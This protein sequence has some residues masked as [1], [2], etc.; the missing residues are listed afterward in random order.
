MG[1]EGQASSLDALGN[2]GGLC[3]AKLQITRSTRN[4]P[5]SPT[6][7]SHAE[8]LSNPVKKG[9]INFSRSPALRAAKNTYNMILSAVR[10]PAVP[11]MDRSAAPAAFEPGGIGGGLGRAAPPKTA[12]YRP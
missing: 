12:V 4:L 9:M 3:W 1:A 7:P 2:P 8:R 10:L 5:N 6:H 11:R